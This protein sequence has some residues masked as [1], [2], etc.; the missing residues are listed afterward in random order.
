MDIFSALAKHSYLTTT[1]PI[2]APLRSTLEVM[3]VDVEMDRDLFVAQLDRVIGQMAGSRSRLIQSIAKSYPAVTN[4]EAAFERNVKGLEA[5]LL[6]L[7]GG[8]Q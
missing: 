5:L 8:E 3:W 4:P 7:K 1:D 2:D 6:D